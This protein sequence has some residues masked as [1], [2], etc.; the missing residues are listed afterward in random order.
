MN[1]NDNLAAQVAELRAEVAHLREQLAKLHTAEAIIRR[2][3]SGLP[4]SVLYPEAK[5][6]RP[7]HL[8]AIK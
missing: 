2:A 1:T 4:D 3:G 6:P 8:K 7:G 5:P